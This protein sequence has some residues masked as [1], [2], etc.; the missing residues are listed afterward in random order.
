M[1][2]RE[3]PNFGT[4]FTG[5]T[6]PIIGLGVYQNTGKCA[7]ACLTALEA[8]YRLIDSAIVYRNEEEVG[9]AI[10]ASG[11]KREDVFVSKPCV[12]QLRH[13]GIPSFILHIETLA[14]KITTRWHGYESTIKAVNESLARFGF[15]V[16]FHSLRY[17][18]CRIE[19]C[20]LGGFWYYRLS[21]SI[22]HT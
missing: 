3:V 5:H 8:N 19:R 11:I 2:G 9:K 10:R 18:F 16:C 1:A 6:M 15:G 7:T 4:C 17:F 22:S 14:S 20:A 12:F 21:R 13:V